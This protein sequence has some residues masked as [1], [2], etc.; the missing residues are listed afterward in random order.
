MAFMNRRSRS[1][2]PL[3]RVETDGRAAPRQDQGA[4]LGLPAIRAAGQL[5]GD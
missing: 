3:H 4:L 5:L 1:A 2:L